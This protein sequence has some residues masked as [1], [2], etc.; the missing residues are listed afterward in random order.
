VHGGA[1]DQ[2]PVWNITGGSVALGPLRRDLAPTYAR[3]INDFRVM[4]SY[5]ENVL[6]P[7]T[8]EAWAKWYDENTGRQ[9]RVDFTVYERSTTRPIGMANLSRINAAHRAGYFGLF[10]GEVDCWGKGYGTETTRLVL[11]Y[12][13]GQAN[14]HNVAL[15]VFADNERAIRMYLRAGFKSAGRR[16]EVHRRGGR[17]V[18]EL[19]MDCLATEF[20][21]GSS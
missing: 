6:R 19:V 12:A 7:R 4:G 8:A 15:T 21:A 11:E 9:D 20:E 5:D 2:A 17:V 18:D 14:M 1:D 3:W 10:I 13:F 16:R